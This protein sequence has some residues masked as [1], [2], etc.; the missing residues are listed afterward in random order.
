MLMPERAH[1]N[2]PLKAVILAGG[3]GKRLRIAV[4]DVPKPMAP[5]AGK[6]FLEHQ[7]RLLKDQ[8]INEIV[9]CVYYMADKIKSYFGDGRS[10]GVDITYSEEEMPLGTGGALKKAEQYLKD[11]PFLVLNGDTYSQIDIEKFYAFH[12]E[13]KSQYTI[14][15]MKASHSLSTGNVI[16]NDGL[17][18]D[19]AEK[20]DIATDT[21]NSGIYLFEPSIFSHIPSNINVS[22]ERETFVQLARSGLLHG[23]HNDGYFIDI[24]LPETYY[25]FRQD[26]LGLLLLKRNNTVREALK[27]IERTGIPILLAV[28][29]NRRLIGT[30]LENEIKQ[31]ILRG[32]NIDAEISAIINTNAMT[33]KIDTSKEQLSTLFDLGLKQIPL[34]DNQGMVRD[35]AFY[36][37]EVR[38]KNYPTVRGQAPLRISFAGGG[39]DLPYFFSEHGGAVLSAT[40]D[41]YCYA[42]MVKR[43]DKKIIIDTDL[44]PEKEIVVKSINELKY[45]GKLDLIK[46]II[47][48]MKPDF[49]FELFMYNDIPPGRGL[50]SSASAAILIASLLNHLQETNFD[51]YKL[52]EIAYRAE[53]EELKIKGGWQDQYAAVTGGFNFMEFNGNKSIIYPLRL[54]EEVVNELNHRLLLCFVGKEHQSGELHSHQEDSF[55]SKP[56]D[57]ILI[58][59]AL[60]NI[61][62]EMK[63][64]L[65]TNNL[66]IFGKLLHDSWE[67][68][69]ILSRHVSNGLVDRLY[70]IGLNNG[71]DG[72]KLLGAGG[73]GYI[74]FSCQPRKRNRL[75]NALQK[76]GGQIMNFNFEFRGTQV[77][78]AKNKV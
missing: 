78:T 44:S 31:Y 10:L 8:G 65:L 55:K 2:L 15:L 42:T 68:K 57:S 67:N 61:A 7:I 62:I 32:G 52:A 51:A 74:L 50:G 11:G 36:T 16:V 39:T 37:E 43:A 40:V 23:Y 24:G 70:E 75:T 54:K 66:D 3:F 13:K 64:V 6:P 41:K 28:D 9:L 26:V 17:I 33:A 18:I 20:Q 60:K 38:T 53:R 27:K 1:K 34:L 63:D 77:W 71:A 69:K 12:Q 22:L 21:I 19:F 76:N 25:Q 58:L 56:E 30:I 14:S 46:A 35:I 73:G 29:D 59:N 47:N 5:I 48:I 49:G 45:D 72:G 4:E